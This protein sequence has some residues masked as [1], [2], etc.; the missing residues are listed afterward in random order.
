MATFSRAK[1]SRLVR[2]NMLHAAINGVPL[3]D[4]AAAMGPQKHAAYQSEPVFQLQLLG[5]ERS[6]LAP[7]SLMHGSVSASGSTGTIA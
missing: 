7:P 4:E 3:P 1:L 2:S 5:K 6:M